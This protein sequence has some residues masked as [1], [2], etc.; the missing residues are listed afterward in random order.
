MLRSVKPTKSPR[1]L[2]HGGC[3][4]TGA[5]RDMGAA[6]NRQGM[7]FTI[8]LTTLFGLPDRATAAEEDLQRARVILEEA[9]RYEERGDCDRAVGGFEEAYA[10]L[11]EP[12]ILLSLGRCYQRLER[13]AEALRAYCWYSDTAPPSA[14]RDEV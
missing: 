13:P 6:M 5:E 3:I 14:R 2:P 4:I 12:E 10:R 7:L 1:T 9:E 11:R 8:T